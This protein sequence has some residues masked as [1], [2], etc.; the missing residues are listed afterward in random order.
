VT[1]LGLLE[2]TL[3]PRRGLD[4]RDEEALDTVLARVYRLM[5]DGRWRTL[6]EI[7][8]ACGCSEAGASARLRELRHDD[9]RLLHPNH[10]VER[11][12]VVGRLWKYRVVVDRADQG[13]GD[14]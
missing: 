3:R 12:R 5:K 8:E 9:V 10:A 1:Q 2:H 4:A 11:E 14:K 7:A 13:R 6:R